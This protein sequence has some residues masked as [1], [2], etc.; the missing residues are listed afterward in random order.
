MTLFC[1][2]GP[3]LT[4][5]PH[6]GPALCLLLPHPHFHVT[7]WAINFLGGELSCLM[8][9]DPIG[10]DTGWPSPS[11][12]TSR[13]SS[14]HSPWGGKAKG[15]GNQGRFQRRSRALETQPQGVRAW[16]DGSWGLTRPLILREI[17]VFLGS[18]S[19][20]HH[21]SPGLCSE[22]GAKVLISPNSLPSGSSPSSLPHQ[23]M[24]K[25]KV[26]SPVPPPPHQWDLGQLWPGSFPPPATPSPQEPTSLSQGILSSRYNRAR[27]SSIPGH[28]STAVP[29]Y[30]GPGLWDSCQLMCLVLNIASVHIKTGFHFL[31]LRGLILHR[32][33]CIFLPGA[34]LPFDCFKCFKQRCNAKHLSMDFILYL[35]STCINRDL[36]VIQL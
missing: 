32:F 4:C 14:P 1:G 19:T 18:W 12:G 6:L 2:D 3:V 5:S 22:L 24:H 34:I 33:G 25:S 30:L 17:S 26:E 28:Q 16:G 36:H 27:A 13:S 20:P 31:I 23:L 11:L 35:N 15:S 7:E 29:V 10:P 9:T 8:W 21:T